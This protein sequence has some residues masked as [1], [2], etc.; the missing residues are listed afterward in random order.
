MEGITA[1]LEETS[2]EPTLP[3]QRVEFPAKLRFLFRHARYKV[4][5]GGRGGGK[6]WGVARAL[7][8]KAAN[9]KIRILCAREYQRSI[10]DSV[11]KLLCEQIEA[12]GLSGA[13]VIT[14]AAIRGVTGSEFI[15]AGIKTDPAQIKSTEGIDIAWVEEAEK[16]SE[17]SWKVLIP[18][19]RK[20][21]SE[22]W[23]TFNPDAETDPTYKRFIVEHPD[24]SVVVAL[25]WS[26][27]P[28]FPEELRKEMEYLQRVD[29][30]ACAHVY[31][32]KPRK[33]GAAQVLRGKCSVQAFE[34]GKDWDG[35]YQGADWGFAA[36][37][38]VL[39]RSWVHANRLWV[40]WEVW[41]V[42]MEINDTATRF[43]T[44]PDARK[45]MTR[46]DSA[47]PETISYLQKHGY[48]NIVGVEKWKGSVE[49]G[50]AFLRQYE[51]IIIH[52]RCVHTSDESRLWSYKQDKLT[53]DVLP[54]L[55]DAHN[56]AWDSIRYA[57]G[58]L[59]KARTPGIFFVG[60]G[61]AA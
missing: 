14:K 42:G 1:N 50:I 31:G 10:A 59:I 35:P 33:H 28:W 60:I 20:P 43:D 17:E 6:S 61:E 46:A 47:R 57:L 40:E 44:I 9:K 13:F 39:T 41:G 34:P 21:R 53:G 36:D 58:P 12:L 38:T 3:T 24:D 22:I 19:V 56:H 5:H 16:V 25:N 27:N 30:D 54:E 26:D 7:I 8:L 48:G 4:L 52:P 49:D 23:V 32:G 11:H 55:V 45:Y 51:Q 2:Q 18:T 15:F 29:P 37:P